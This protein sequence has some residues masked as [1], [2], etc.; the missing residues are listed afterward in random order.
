MSKLW[1]HQRE[2]IGICFFHEDH[3]VARSSIRVITAK[4]PEWRL[5]PECNEDESDEDEG[6]KD[7]D[8]EDEGTSS[9]YL[10]N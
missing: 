9:P 7:E 3:S 10:C 8:T 6:S 2:N 5:L 1:E 4:E